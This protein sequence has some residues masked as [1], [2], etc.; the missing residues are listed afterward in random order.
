MEG[1]GTFA[2]FDPVDTGAEV[3]RRLGVEGSIEQQVSERRPADGAGFA[4]RVV[5]D[6]D[7]GPVA[8]AYAVQ[9]IDRHAGGKE[10]GADAQDVERLDA[11]RL[12]Q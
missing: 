9:A 6:V 11:L 7:Q 12:Y 10:F 2:C 8:V 4:L 5:G 3:D 1:A